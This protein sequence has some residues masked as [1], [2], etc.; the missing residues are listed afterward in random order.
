MTMRLQL[1]LPD[2]AL[3]IVLILLCS[4]GL[5]LSVTPQAL[6]DTLT[7]GKSCPVFSQ[8]ASPS[9]VG[10]LAFSQPWYHSGRTDARY[11]AGD[12]ATGI[13]LEIH[14]FANTQG[15]VK[16][17]NKAACNR[18]RL[19]Q[20]RKTTAQ[21]FEGE[22]AIQIDI[23]DEAYTPFYDNSPMEHGYGTHQT[24]MDDLDKPWSGRP[25][26]ASTVA[27]YDTPYVSDSYGVEGQHIRTEFETCVICERDMG[28]DSLLSC[29][30]WG[31][32]RDYLN[33]ETGWTEPEIIP[34]ECLQKPSDRFRQTLESSNQVAYHYWLQWR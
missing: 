20:I 2:K 19:L 7:V 4:L 16:G 21:L 31:Y 18:Y 10:I 22:K 33:E 27:I 13:G 23:P 9:Q 8:S 14:F 1:H 15:T 5:T 24:P 34:V 30:T 11:V 6:A 17:L 26:R 29:G 3:A 25:V 32:Q 12:N 28:Y